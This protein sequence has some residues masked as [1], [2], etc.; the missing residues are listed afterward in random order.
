M[1]HTE[2][3]D[4]LRLKFRFGSN[5]ISTW[6]QTIHL[7]ATRSLTKSRNH[8][9][10][11]TLN[12]S[13]NLMARVT[14]WVQSVWE[15]SIAEWRKNLTSSKEDCGINRSVLV[16]S[17]FQSWSFP[18]WIFWIDGTW[19]VLGDTWQRKQGRRRA[20]RTL[21]QHKHYLQVDRIW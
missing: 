2:D 20:A 5:S 13:Q 14:T 21:S 7:D 15:Q 1:Q 17:G 18:R 9:N 8:W 12:S 10:G 3:P 11:A 19:V 4:R 16:D 6:R